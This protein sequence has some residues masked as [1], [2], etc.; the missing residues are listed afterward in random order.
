MEFLL[1][2]TTR[3]SEKSFNFL[4]TLVSMWNIEKQKLEKNRFSQ[5]YLLVFVVTFMV[6]QLSNNN[7]KIQ[8]CLLYINHSQF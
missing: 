3:E 2:V 6:K 1:L 5:N 7:S 8:W 4:L